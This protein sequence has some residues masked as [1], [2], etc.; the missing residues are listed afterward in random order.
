QDPA[1]GQVFARSGGDTGQI[2]GVIKDYNF[3][4]L[5]SKIQPM[6]IACNTN[7]DWQTMFFATITPGK[8]PGAMNAIAATWKQ[9]IPDAPFE[10][11]FMDQAFDNLYKDDL[12]I[13][14]LVLI[15]SCISITISALGLLGLGTFI[16]EQ[17]TKEIGI[18]KVLGASV[19]QIVTMLSKDFAAL[20]IIAV[21]IASPIAYWALNS[22]LQN[23]V[24]RINLSWWIFLASGTLALLIALATISGQAIKAA[25]ANPVKS[26]RS[27]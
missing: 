2:I 11:Q 5:Y 23:F 12:K 13:S 25:I 17:R 8:I 7:D 1:V 22:W 27:E 24:Y 4:S 14:R 10:Y 21:V 18:R 20:V 15:F 6:V 19:T 9:F 26:L 3:N 16:A